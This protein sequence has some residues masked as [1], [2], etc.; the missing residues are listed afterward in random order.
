MLKPEIPLNRISFLMFLNMF[1]HLIERP[2]F[3]SI[4]SIRTLDE[5]TLSCG[6]QHLQIPQRTAAMLRE[7]KIY[8]IRDLTCIDREFIKRN[9]PSN[10]KRGLDIFGSTG[11]SV[12]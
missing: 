7:F 6:I 8:T 11:I 1:N 4:E 9:P 5:Q 10:G 3:G 2:L 12:G